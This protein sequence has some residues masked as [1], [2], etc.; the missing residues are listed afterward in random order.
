MS[1]P[2]PTTLLAL[3]TQQRRDALLALRVQQDKAESLR[4]LAW[5][6]GSVSTR[7]R[8]SPGVIGRKHFPYDLWGDA[9]NTASM[10]SAGT[11]GQ[12]QVTAATRELLETDLI[13]ERRRTVE[14]KGK[15]EMET[16]YLVGPRSAAAAA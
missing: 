12:I 9:V 13:F 15:G 2:I 7:G 14:V 6:F 8:W 4:T 16:W 3:F 11:A 10:E 5:S 1:A